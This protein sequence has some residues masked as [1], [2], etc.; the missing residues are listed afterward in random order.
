[1]GCG[2]LLHLEAVPFPRTNSLESETISAQRG[3][4]FRGTWVVSAGL[5]PGDSV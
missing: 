2:L 3:G 4:A 1:M 5:S